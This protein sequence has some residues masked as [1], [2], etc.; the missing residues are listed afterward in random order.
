M[1]VNSVIFKFADC[2]EL[3]NK[4]KELDLSDILVDSGTK[5]FE[6]GGQLA[7]QFFGE[8][9]QPTSAQKEG[10]RRVISTF[11]TFGDLFAEQ[12]IE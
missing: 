2:K 10:I 7:I 4:F 11:K 3:A 9:T 12:T 8:L 5:V 1:K 6:V